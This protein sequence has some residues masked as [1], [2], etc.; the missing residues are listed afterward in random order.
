MIA[1]LALLIACRK[2]V[3]PQVTPEAEPPAE[4]RPSGA[5]GGGMYVDRRWPLVVPVPEGWTA[6]V[7]ADDAPLRMRAQDPVTGA[8]VEVYAL[9]EGT[10]GPLDRPEC[11]WTFQDTGRYRMITTADPITVATCTPEEPTAPH[12]FAVLVVRPGVVWELDLRAPG[13]SLAA[14]VAAGEGLLQGVRF[15]AAF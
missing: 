13:T 14:A 6:E 12:R 2:P 8:E 3:P 15:G 9:P 1:G 4:V 7:G 10:T 11:S 5:L